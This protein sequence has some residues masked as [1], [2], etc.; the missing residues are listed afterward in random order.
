MTMPARDRSHYSGSYDKRARLVRERA[1]ADPGT[2][3]WRCGRT[4]A[5]EQRLVPWKRVAWH[6]GHTVDGDNS[7]PLMPEHSTCNQRA[8]AMA[9]NLARNP[10]VARWW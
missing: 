6:A 8:G 4:L 10:K 2:R 7:A 3:C 5:E 1:Y 9:G